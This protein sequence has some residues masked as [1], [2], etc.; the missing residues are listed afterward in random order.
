[1]LNSTRIG[2][3]RTRLTCTPGRVSRRNRRARSANFRNRK[4]REISSPPGA[5]DSQAACSRRAARTY[6]PIRRKAHRMRTQRR[7]QFTQARSYA[8]PLGRL[9]TKARGGVPRA[10]VPHFEAVTGEGSPSTLDEHLNLCNYPAVSHRLG[11][12]GRP[13][14]ADRPVISLM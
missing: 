11:S 7:A 10:A 13:F 1:M 2:N 12:Q 9:D 3:E 4:K 5:S 6:A 8:D 14:A